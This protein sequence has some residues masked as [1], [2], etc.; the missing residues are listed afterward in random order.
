[1][2]ENSKELTVKVTDRGTVTDRIEENVKV[3]EHCMDAAEKLATLLWGPPCLKLTKKFFVANIRTFPAPGSAQ[4]RLAFLVGSCRYP[5]LMWKIK[6]ADRIFG[7][8][9]VLENLLV[10]TQ[11]RHGTLWGRLLRRDEGPETILLSLHNPTAGGLLGAQP[12]AVLTIVSSKAM[13]SSRTRRR[14]WIL[15]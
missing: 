8:M 4:D 6:E 11:E 9:T 13:A 2:R 7:P 5:G 12:T 14:S 15:F 1:L 10:A 3:E